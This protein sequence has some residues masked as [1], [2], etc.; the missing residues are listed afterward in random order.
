[1]LIS[2]G[3]WTELW[4]QIRKGE[5]EL[6]FEGVPT[7]IFEWKSYDPDKGFEP[8]FISYGTILGNPLGLFFKCDDCH[9]ENTTVKNFDVYHPIGLWSKEEL[10]VYNNFSLSMRGVGVV[11]ILLTS[12]VEYKNQYLV[13]MDNDKGIWYLFIQIIHQ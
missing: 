3:K 8:M 1:M 2:I 13:K 11:M 9:T 10:P 5:I 12:V 4:L 7:A 6:G